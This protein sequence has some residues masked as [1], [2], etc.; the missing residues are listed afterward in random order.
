MLPRILIGNART[1]WR[2]EVK[3]GY[4][5]WN[6]WAEVI[7]QRFSR[8]AWFRHLDGKIQG[9]RFTQSNLENPTEWA[10]EFLL[11]LESYDA[12][13]GEHPAPLLACDAL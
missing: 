11:L 6:Q 5:S 13:G 3:R 2:L 9:H 7:T 4:T 10:N 8:D 12:N 1:W